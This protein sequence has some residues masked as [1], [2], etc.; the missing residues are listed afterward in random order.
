M[1][2]K[3]IDPKSYINA[4]VTELFYTCNELHDLFYLYGFDEAYVPPRLLLRLD[5]RLT[6]GNRAGNFQQYNFGKEGLGGDAVIANA[7]DG[8]GCTSLRP[9]SEE[10]ALTLA[11][12]TTPTLRPVSRIRSSRRPR[13]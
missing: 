3:H 7:Q 2:G 12:T 5:P 9:S 6:V 13:G 10:R 11:Q 1:T 8:S 4:S